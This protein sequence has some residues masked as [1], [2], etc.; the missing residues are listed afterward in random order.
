MPNTVLDTPSVF[1]QLPNHLSIYT[2]V[3]T[4][5]YLQ[6]YL[7]IHIYW[8]GQKVCLGFSITSYGKKAIE[9][10]GQP[11][12]MLRKST[13]LTSQVVWLAWASTRG[14]RGNTPGQ[15]RTW[16]LFEASIEV[17]VTVYCSSARLPQWVSRLNSPC[18]QAGSTR[19]GLA[20][21]NH[22][23]GLRFPL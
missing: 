10:F 21:G 14:K 16:V 4:H 11:N 3:Y 20:D 17:S 22:V 6:I 9:H 15:G 13:V 23:A 8:V 1:S 7:S 19:W 2:Y 18:W 5:P 12:W